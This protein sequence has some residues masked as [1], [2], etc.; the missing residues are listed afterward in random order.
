MAVFDRVQRQAHI[1]LAANL[2]A[3][4]WLLTS[5]SSSPPRAHAVPRPPVLLISVDGLR[6]EFYRS[7]SGWEA[8]TLQ[9]LAAQGA[10]AD[11]AETIFPS[12]TYPSHTTIVTG[13]R[14]ARHGVVSNTIF[15]KLDGPTSTWYWD[16]EL[17]TAPTIWQRARAA[18][19]KTAILTWPGNV[20]GQA[21]WLIPEI[22]PSPPDLTGTTWDLMQKHMLPAFA[23][24]LLT[25]NHGDTP[26]SFGTRD[27]WV[28]A[29]AE[30][31]L[32]EQRPDFTLIHIINVDHAAHEF[33]KDSPQVHEALQTADAQLARILSAVDLT[34]TTLI[35][36]GDHGFYDYD[37]T[38]RPNVLFARQGWLHE[39][40]TSDGV[41]IRKDW[42]VITQPEGGAAS[43]YTRDDSL[44]PRIVR[45]LKKNAGHAYRVIERAE[46][47]EREA[48]PG[49]VCAISPTTSSP[50]GAGYSVGLDAHGRFIEKLPR[51]RGNHGP[52]PEDPLLQTG[53]IAV[54]PGIPAG[55]RLGHV[56]LLDV[57][58]TIARLIDVPFSEAEG[59]PIDLSGGKKL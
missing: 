58:P 15:S 26:D 28:T 48:F 49:A 5:C 2:V 6:P 3:I 7:G 20:G 38:I 25:V 11:S 24:E 37:K 16:S 46:L 57:A 31:V 50:G 45:L 10:F 40:Q 1:H 36:L 54:G 32:S 12:L 47:D 8:P 19:L 17:Q 4:S 14:S 53:L 27:A 41:K 29:A 51:V 59:Q 13:V 22:F 42:Q 39:E 30:H 9:K 35:L 52:V 21:D 44:A 56:R 43:I 34:K 23:Q 18:G 55:T 33:G